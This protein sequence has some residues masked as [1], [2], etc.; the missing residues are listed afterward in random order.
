MKQALGF[1]MIV[2]LVGASCKRVS[3][4]TKKAASSVKKKVENVGDRVIPNFD[5]QKPDTRFNKRRFADF[6]G[7]EAGADVS[8]LYCYADLM[9]TDHS[10][11]FAFQCDESTVERIISQRKLKLLNSP[12]NSASNLRRMFDW[13]NEKFVVRTPPYFVKEEHESYSYL[14]FDK[15]K[16]VAYYFTFD[17]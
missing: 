7:F 13:W 6:F 4:R 5:S 16:E 15:S 14:W 3:N 8:N 2:C 11:Q 17:M 10:Y 12:E 1:L 9:G